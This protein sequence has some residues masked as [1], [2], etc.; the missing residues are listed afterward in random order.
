MNVEELRLRTFENW[1]DNAV[2]E[3]YRVAA[4]GFY[5]NGPGLSVK[6][7]SCGS[8]I[9]EWE[10]G[11]QI[12]SKHRLLNPD[13]VFVRDPER[14]GNIPLLPSR[15]SLSP[16]QPNDRENAT[17]RQQEPSYG[18]WVSGNS[19]YKNEQARLDS[20]S[21]W[22]IPFIVRPEALAATGF[23]FLRQGDKVCIVA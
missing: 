15:P 1:P 6:C 8:E 17:P 22:P 20:F 10:Y 13:C 2:V 5:S 12:M 14:A 16:S 4:A 7:F 23:Y 19:I 3:P 9:T 11:D 18:R 21:D